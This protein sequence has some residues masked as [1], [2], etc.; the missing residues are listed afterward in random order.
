MFQHPYIASGGQDLIT[1]VIFVVV[2]LAQIVK[3]A[4]GKK[5]TIAAP[6]TSP[7]NEGSYTAPE[8]EL[9][10]FLES[11]SGAPAAHEESRPAQPPPVATHVPAP[12]PR[13]HPVPHAQPE[14]LVAPRPAPHPTAQPTVAAA[15]KRVP[16]ETHD[17]VSRPAALPAPALR[18]Y[19]LYALQSVKTTSDAAGN[20]VVHV[21]RET[22]H[23][24][25]EL[26][27]QLSDR[28]AIRKAIVLREILGPCLALRR[29]Q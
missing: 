13:P 3:A 22:H 23:F 26:F 9:R 19:E 15:V 28:E 2:I 14:V 16:V 8:D 18:P 4:K 20:P 25:K 17:V 1:L 10:K 7:A 11:L 24:R 12:P 29:S 5:P 27:A 21:H 6:G